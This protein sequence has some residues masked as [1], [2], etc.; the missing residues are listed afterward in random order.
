MQHID[1]N[2][3]SACLNYWYHRPLEEWPPEPIQEPGPIRSDGRLN[4]WCTQTHRSPSEQKKLV[5]HWCDTLPTL[6]GVR[7][8]WLG[9]R[10]PQNLFDAACRIPNLESLYIKWSGIKKLD[11]LEKAVSLRYLHIGSSTGVE[12][13]EPLRSLTS[14]KWLGLE[15]VTRVES[16]D[17]LCDLVNLYGLTVEGSLWTKQV[18]ETLAPVGNL[19]RLRYLSII[20][21]QS[22]DRTLSPLFALTHLEVFHSASW[23]SQSEVA[24]LFRRNPKLTE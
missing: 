8:L 24:E 22:R 1:I 19:H 17:P 6:T 15:S 12:S 5:A 10:V 9:S 2:D 18:V 21:L 16:L 20:N 13:I 14:L 4:L 7:H 11:A 3:K 23:W